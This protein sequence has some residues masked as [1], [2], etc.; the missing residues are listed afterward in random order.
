M[1]MD[2]NSD[3]LKDSY[4]ISNR[5]KNYFSQLLNVHMLGRWKYIYVTTLNDGAKS[6]SLNA[7]N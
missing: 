4:N 3:L 7:E 2:E 6:I 1:A 5:W